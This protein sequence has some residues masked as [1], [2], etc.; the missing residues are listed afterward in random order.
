MSVKQK[1][2]EN[3]LIPGKKI[4]DLIWVKDRYVVM[5]DFVANAYEFTSNDLQGNLFLSKD[6]SQKINDIIESALK[7]GK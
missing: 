4:Y 1:K 6:D 2:M 7:K 3:I 5:Q